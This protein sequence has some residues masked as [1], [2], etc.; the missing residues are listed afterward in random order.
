MEHKI[1]F[2]KDTSKE[3]YEDHIDYN[4]MLIRSRETHF[5]DVLTVR[6]Y[7]YLNYIYDAF[8]LRWNPRWENHCIIR[9]DVDMIRF[10]TRKVKDGYNITITW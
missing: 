2:N 10:K 7:V 6:G 1:K 8:G 9:E 5:N 4:R 3:F